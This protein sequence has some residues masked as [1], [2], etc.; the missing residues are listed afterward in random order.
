MHTCIN[1]L[2]KTRLKSSIYKARVEIS[3][4]QFGK[5]GNILIFLILQQFGIFW[6]NNV[7]V[8]RGQK[9]MAKVNEGQKVVHLMIT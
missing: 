7:K 9:L 1:F 3:F 6:K 4:D 8:K 5:L 2:K